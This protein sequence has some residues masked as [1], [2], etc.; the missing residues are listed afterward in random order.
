MFDKMSSGEVWLVILGTVFLSM[1]VLA[2]WY[3]LRERVADR[4]WRQ[5]QAMRE[6]KLAAERRNWEQEKLVREAEHLEKEREYRLDALRTE[7]D[8]REAQKQEAEARA[9]EAL[10]STVSGSGGYIVVEMPER[11]RPLFHDLLKGFEDFAKLRG[12]DLSFSIDTSVE[13]RIAFKF[14]V[15]DDGVVV[16]SERVRKDFK[17]YLERARSG[18]VDELD[19]LPIVVSIEEHHLLITVLK[20]RL[21]FLQHSYKLS[22]NAVIYYEY[23][24]DR[25][26]TFPALPAPSVI[27]QTGG[28]MDSRKYNAV[29]SSRLIQG[30]ANAFED[31]STNINI[32]KSLNERNEQIAHLDN[33][34]KHL[35]AVPG[36]DAAKQAARE[37][38]KAKDELAEAENP[39]P[40]AVSRWMHHAKDLLSAA[41]V[42]AEVLEAA[43]KAFE[44][45]GI[46]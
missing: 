14:T 15:K 39:E 42:G 21:N 32:G 37:I 24:I 38:S 2:G 25:H 8:M 11:E 20:N 30:E 17:E 9:A 44:A 27:V 36:D 33:L 29:N 12:Y 4:R 23:L 10:N 43:K 6:E 34:L 22:Q 46:C 16:G 31:S 1:L 35:E 7:S 18:N 5:E 26:R 28:N 41:S 19:D 40:S 13:G 3:M 45:F